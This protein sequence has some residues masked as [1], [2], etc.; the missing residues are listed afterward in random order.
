MPRIADLPHLLKLL[1]DDSTVVREAVRR[2]L[3]AM[4]A[5]LPARIATLDHPLTEEQERILG[6]LL[7]PVCRE[8]LEESWL[9]WKLLHTPEAQLEHALAQIAAFLGGWQARPSELSHKLEMLAAQAHEDE[10]EGDPRRLAEFLFGGHGRRPRFRGNSTSYYS[11]DNSNLLWVIE[12]GL[13]NPISLCCIYMLVGA[14]LGIKVEGCNFPGHFLA[15]VTAGDGSWL[16]DCFNR[17]RFLRAED[18]ARHHPA[19]NPS[20]SEV[21]EAEASPDV[22]IGRTLR[23]LDEAFARTNDLASRQVVRRLMLQMMEA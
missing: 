14:R 18:V 15:R 1:D 21:I 2:E 6:E 9:S 8:E 10:C 11:A 4:R 12:H 23:N 16:V 17:G 5:D 22:I 20:L 3:A 19:A 7:A 13:G